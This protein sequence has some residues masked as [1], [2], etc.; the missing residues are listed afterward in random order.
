MKIIADKRIVLESLYSLICTK[1]S[2]S[3]SSTGTDSNDNMS[4]SD[5]EREKLSNMTEKERKS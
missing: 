2:E 3:D 5:T 1:M 4:T